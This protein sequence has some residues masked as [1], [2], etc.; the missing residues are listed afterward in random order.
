MA[1]WFLPSANAIED[2]VYSQGRVCV[3]VRRLQ[4]CGEGLYRL[5][6]MNLEVRGG[7]TRVYHMLVSLAIWCR[8]EVPHE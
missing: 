2:E 4:T 5:S 7:K 8:I 1:V 3:H 6:T